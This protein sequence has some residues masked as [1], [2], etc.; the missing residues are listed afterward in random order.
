MKND[1]IIYRPNEV[2]EHIEV[3]LENETV[4]LNQEQISIL[5]QRDQSVISRHIRDLFRGKKLDEKSKYAK[6]AY[7]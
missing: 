3:R 7:S 5:F 1:I 2:D 6:S 4:W